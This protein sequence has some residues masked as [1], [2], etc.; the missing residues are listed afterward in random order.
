M[1]ATF[2]SEETVLPYVGVLVRVSGLLHEGVP[3]RTFGLIGHNADPRDGVSFRR[4]GVP[5][6]AHVDHSE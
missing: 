5:N 3:R 6:L 1:A 4:K 2:A